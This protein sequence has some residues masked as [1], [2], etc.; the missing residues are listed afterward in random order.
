MQADVWYDLVLLELAGTD[1]LNERLR[2]AE[3]A[4]MTTPPAQPE[5]VEQIPTS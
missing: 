5:A 1:P 3:A 4:Q 2:E